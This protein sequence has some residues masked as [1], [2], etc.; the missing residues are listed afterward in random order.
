[1][2]GL[3]KCFVPFL[4]FYQLKI[5]CDPLLVPAELC[6]S[7][8]IFTDVSSIFDRVIL[9]GRVSGNWEHVCGL[10]RKLHGSDILNV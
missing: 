9:L 2:A 6:S 7:L 1:M 5:R 3:L 4:H 10:Q 8:S